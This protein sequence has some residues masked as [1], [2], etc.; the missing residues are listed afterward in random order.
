MNGLAITVVVILAALSGLHLY[1][2]VGGLWPG[3]DASDL[4]A[5][6]VGTQSR[7]P[8]GFMA[9]AVVALA[10]LAAAYVIGAT[11]WFADPLGL[12]R[13]FW[14]TGT[15]VVGAVFLLRGIAAY[16]PRIFDYAKGTPFFNLNRLYYAPLC[17]L[18]AA[19]IA[20]ATL[21]T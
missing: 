20:A 2:G 6:V 10:L 5:R 12:P 13:W 9:C 3:R 4:A 1:W 15:A 21:S 17:L 16:L 19:G 18:I 7:S 8:P 14:L 11:T